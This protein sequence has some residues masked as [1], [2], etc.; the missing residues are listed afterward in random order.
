MVEVAIATALVGMVM[1]GALQGATLAK[2]THREQG[3]AARGVL[4][5]SELLAE[6]CSMSYADPEF[7][8][9]SM[10]ADAGESAF[11]RTWDDVDDYAGFT[12][13]PLY[14]RPG[15]QIPGFEKWR[16]AVSV[17]RVSPDDPETAVSDD[18]GLKKITVAATSPDGKQIEVSGLRARAG[19]LD[20]GPPVAFTAAV[21][22]GAALVLPNE[23]GAHRA[24]IPLTNH[25]PAAP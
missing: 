8:N 4:L 6:I 23:S 21:Q 11:P 24:A 12:Q 17:V 14:D 13:S 7:P 3:A 25:A 16:L 18:E 9:A 10:G 2:R 20:P 5:A 22:L 15:N 19:G 1:L